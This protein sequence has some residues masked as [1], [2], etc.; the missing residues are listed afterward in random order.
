MGPDVA[1]EGAL[2]TQDLLVTDPAVRGQLYIS[3]WSV[4]ILFFLVR[5]S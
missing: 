1:L 4:C 2:V 3:S 5:M